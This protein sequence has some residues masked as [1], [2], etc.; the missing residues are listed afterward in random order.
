[1]YYFL[2]FHEFVLCI[3]SYIPIAVHYKM[4]CATT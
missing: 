3:Y 2:L 1:M 4:F